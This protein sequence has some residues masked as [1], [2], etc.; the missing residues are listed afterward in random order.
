MKKNNITLKRAVVAALAI[1]TLSAQG[2]ALALGLGD[3]NIKSHLGQPLRASIK[4]QGVSGLKNL[5]CF[6]LG[7]DS[8]NINQINQANLKLNNVRGD[9]AILTITTSEAILEPIASLTIVA[10]CDSTLSR[11]YVL[12]ID[13][14]LTAETADAEN[15]GNDNK[16]DENTVTTDEN[17]NSAAAKV[18]VALPQSIKVGAAVTSK[19][20]SA[21][22]KRA[23]KQN[24]NVVLTANYGA[25]NT[26]AANVEGN[27]SAAPQ[28]LQKPTL[29]KS[30]LPKQGQARLSVSGLESLKVNPDAIGTPEN[31]AG[32]SSNGSTLG[33]PSLSIDRQLHF[34][35]ET[36]A[37]ALAADVAMQ[38]EATVLSNR[39][40]H[41][42]NQI[43]TLQQRNDV[44]EAEKKLKAPEAIENTTLAASLA[45]AA[46]TWWP[47]LF[48]AS[49]LAAGYFAAD[50][51]RRRR[52]TIQLENAEEVWDILDSNSNNSLYFKEYDLGDDLFGLQTNQANVETASKPKLKTDDFEATQVVNVPIQLEDNT[53]HNILDHADVFLS[54][55]RTSLAIQL[56]QNHLLDFPKQSV[57]IWLFL[58]DLLAKENLPA[59]YEQTALECKEHF[60]IRV[61]DFSNDEASLKQSFEDF[62]RLTA[63]LEQVWGTTAALSY[64]DDLIYNSRLETRVGFDKNV[65][66][67]LILLRSIAQEAL[68]SAEVIQMDE[69]KMMIKERKDA[70]IAANKQTKLLKMDELQLALQP[71]VEAEATEARHEEL[72]EFNLVEFK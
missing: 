55:G 27:I 1:L 41:L 62:P 69:K 68:K 44:L 5:D 29:A 54:H 59:V 15:E 11:D 58:L 71:S 31:S 45:N 53:E 52:Q 36:A 57:T 70:Q 13:P 30:S 48:G 67:E 2:N 4:V 65:L 17:N 21:K 49:L 61:A 23:N 14:A 47:Y 72:F 3:I 6:R 40:A 32:Q 39:L 8:G 24:N 63:G 38:D 56:L 42:E 9:D 43:S 22:K 26:D 34:T 66:E 7:A 28:S 64:L 19:K 50:F 51:W 16:G 18:V 37:Q 12:L 20:S 46:L 33:R 10:E 25:N 35:A 60:N